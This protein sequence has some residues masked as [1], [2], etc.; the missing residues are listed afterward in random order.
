MSKHLDDW[1]ARGQTS[2]LASHYKLFRNKEQLGLFA[3]CKEEADIYI[4]TIQN[5]HRVGLNGEY[6]ST[7][8]TIKCHSCSWKHRL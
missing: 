4:P 7:L 5:C 2:S 6:E 8:L 3:K 1:P